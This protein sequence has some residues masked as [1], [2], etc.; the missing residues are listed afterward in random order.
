M[1]KFFVLA[2]AAAMALACSKDTPTVDGSGTG[3]GNENDNTQ[4][5]KV[6]GVV[7]N[8][9]CGNRVEYAGF[10]AANKFIEL[11]NASEAE[12]NLAGWTIRKYAPDAETVQGEYDVVWTGP[13]TMKLA[14][15]AY[16][17]LEA[18]TDDPAKG[19]NAG[20]SAK[21]GVKFELVDA[22]G[23]VVD[24]FVRG[25]DTT[26]FNEIALEG[27]KEHKTESFSR[28]DLT[29][30]WA[31]ALPTPGAANGEKTTEIEHE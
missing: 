7:F 19:F 21:K 8:E 11:Y 6:E 13:E 23:K 4:T 22:T 10:E 24:K 18:D 30:E 12:A 20:L 25:E 17:V 5:S 2:A 15:G 16:L 28:I 9:L 1:K 31:Y 29:T 14:A 27:P 3:A 26:P